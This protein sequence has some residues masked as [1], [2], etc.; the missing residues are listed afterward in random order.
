MLDW[1]PVN[2]PLTTARFSGLYGIWYPHASN[3]GAFWRALAN[4]PEPKSTEPLKQ[5]AA[6]LAAEF[7]ASQHFNATAYPAPLAAR[8]QVMWR[9]GWSPAVGLT[10]STDFDSKKDI[11]FFA[12]EP[13][14]WFDVRLRPNR[15][16][17]SRRT[18]ET[19]TRSRARRQA[20]F[21][22]RAWPSSRWTSRSMTRTAA[23]RRP[24]SPIRSSS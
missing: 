2:E 1:T 16:G 23:S 12:G 20:S 22:V 19:W 14:A 5:L 24:P 11:G 7:I 8:T 3:E 4:Q 21:R 15:S 9:E 10:P 6:S 13:A 18:S 17:V